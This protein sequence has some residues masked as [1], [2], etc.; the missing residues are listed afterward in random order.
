MS[1]PELVTV[2]ADEIRDV[3][4]KRIE[5]GPIA[6]LL[7]LL[8]NLRA[9]IDAGPPAPASLRTLREA[10]EVAMRE[11]TGVLARWDAAQKAARQ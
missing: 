6:T 8:V 2:I 10:A 1:S 11:T 7:A 4:A 9:V 3:I 5:Q